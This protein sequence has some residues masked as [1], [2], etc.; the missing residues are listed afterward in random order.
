MLIMHALVMLHDGVMSRAAGSVQARI[1]AP[2]LAERRVSDRLPF[3]AEMVMVWNHDLQTP[4]RYRMQDAG[5]GGY[6]IRT[7]APLV[8]GM[9]GM[10]IRLL[11]GRGTRLDQ[12]VMVVWAHAADDAPGEYDAG[13]RCF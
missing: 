3:P 8:E 9:T 12:P 10:V 13:L 6:R 11:P 2:D 5:H 1:E 7:S 4:M